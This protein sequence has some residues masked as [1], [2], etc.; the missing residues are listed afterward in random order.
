M[1]RVIVTILAFF[2][3]VISP[4]GPASAEN[5]ADH[6]APRF[7]PERATRP[8]TGG[9]V[10][11]RVDLSHLPTTL[12]AA[13]KSDLPARHDARELGIVSP[14]K[15]QGAC[16]SCYAF[17]AAGDLEARVL[18]DYGALAD[19]SENH[20]KECHFEEQSCAGGGAQIVANLLTAVGAVDEACDPY[21]ASD[22][23]C[24]DGCD[25]TFA[26]L[27]WEWIAGGAMPAT[28]LLKQAILDHG[29]ISTTVYAGDG[30]APTW[31]GQFSGWNGGDGLYYAG[32]ETNNHAVMIVGWDDD[33]PHAGGGTGCWIMRNSWGEGWGD[34]CGHGDSGGYCYIA[35]GS[36]GIGKISSVIT[37]VMPT[38]PELAVLGWD[39][40]G[41]TTS[42]GYDAAV[43][44]GM[45][46]IE[47][48]VATNLHRVE[49]WTT[50][51]TTD[52]DV[53]IYDQFSG[54]SPSGLLAS[55]NDLA[56][57]AS[58]YHSV[59]LDAPLALHAGQDYYVVVRFQ[60]S[61][62][63]YPLPV[64]T[65]GSCAAGTSWGSHGGSTWTDL[66]SAH[67]CELGI[68]A[69]T[70][71]YM[72][73]P[74][75]A[76]DLPPTPAIDRRFALE[77]PWPNP[78]NPA[79]T[80]TYTVGRESSVNLRIFDLQGRLVRTLVGETVPAG[81]HHVRWNGRDDGQR[82]VAAGVYLC[83]LDDGWQQ[84][85]RRLVLVR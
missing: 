45:A 80:L 84:R 24:L 73:L 41:W 83:R 46:R 10:P 13:A 85:S 63:G 57:S 60:N 19:A 53:S 16:G 75:E 38:Y 65:Q 3:I 22:V 77:A 11:P 44:W 52:V 28:D 23:A 18:R 43:A 54:G 21:Q 6:P 35:Y 50:D 62:Y 82:P 56:F 40:G 49:F 30:Q 5:A 12:S 69:R 25:P 74:I 64:D 61:S 48:P 20:L 67:G 15:N 27:S 72:V 51:V 2:V 37:E 8:L 33:H 14:V 17:A 36:A 71:P 34:A 79:T 70:G 39:E 68:R 9:F 81:R 59:P 29:P 47:S 76:D 42:F 31:Q 4:L 55:I 26:A 66:G 32:D 78:F 58:G 7:A 1:S